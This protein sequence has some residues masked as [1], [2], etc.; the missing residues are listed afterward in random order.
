MNMENIE[1]IEALGIVKLVKR[2][3]KDKVL[4]D[5]K[6][7]ESKMIGMHY[8]ICT[9]PLGR[10]VMEDGCGFLEVLDKGD[11]YDVSFK[12][13]ATGLEYITHTTATQQR[14][15]AKTYNEI[16]SY[17]NPAPKETSKNPEGLL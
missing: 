4:K 6:E 3:Y 7:V 13:T 9:S 8:W 1:T 12:K 14:S 16:Q 5:G 2:Q 10:F 17:R 15:F 11:L